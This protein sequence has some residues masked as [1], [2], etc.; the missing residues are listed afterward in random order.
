MGKHVRSNVEF[1]ELDSKS[2]IEY[3]PTRKKMHK[4]I[5]YTIK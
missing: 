3:D 1:Y 4:G 5:K 2:Y